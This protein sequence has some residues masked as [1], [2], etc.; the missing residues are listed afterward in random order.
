MIMLYRPHITLCTNY[1]LTKAKKIANEIFEPFEANI[2]YLWVYNQNMDL[3]K[4]Y[5][6]I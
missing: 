4:E 2:K 3:I 5:E 6:L 1:N